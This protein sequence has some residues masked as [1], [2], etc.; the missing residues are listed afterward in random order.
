[1]FCPRGQLAGRNIVATSGADSGKI[2][3]YLLPI[4]DQREHRLL[5]RHAVRDA[6]LELAG[7]TTH[8]GDAEHDYEAHYRWLRELTDGR[9]ELE[10]TL[11]ITCIAPAG[12]CPISRS[13]RCPM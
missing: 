13:T 8:M 2:L 5:N 11:P 1:V 9:S 12:G 10:H 7:S 6:L 4:F 3:T